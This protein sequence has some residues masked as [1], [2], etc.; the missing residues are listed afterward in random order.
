M[1]LILVALAGAA[2]TRAMPATSAGS[3][4]SDF[5]YPA[6][7]VKRREEGPVGFSML[8]APDGKVTR[9]FVTKSSGFPDLDQRTCPI[10]LVRTKFKS[11]RDENGSPLY[12]LYNGTLT[13]RLPGKGIGRPLPKSPTVIEPDMII[14]VQQLPGGMEE[15]AVSILTRT[16][17][18]GHIAFCQ[19]NPTYKNSAAL[20][21]VA[22]TQAKALYTSD[23]KDDAGNPLPIIQP[24]RV[25]FRV[26]P[27]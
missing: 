6:G 11:A 24:F 23:M 16:D 21:K 13:W 12:D 1:S 8:V 25:G 20:V 19:S 15:E 3:W 26:A 17:T 5:D 18:T 27:K 10:M 4:L 22:C 14:E 2:L 9:C 7:S